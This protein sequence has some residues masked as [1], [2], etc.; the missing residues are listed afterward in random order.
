MSFV[1]IDTISPKYLKRA[2]RV[3][4]IFVPDFEYFF[5]FSNNSM[6]SIYDFIPPEV[7]SGFLMET[8]YS[9]Y[10][11]RFHEYYST[12]F[13]DYKNFSEK[14]RH[15]NYID[16]LKLY[17]LARPDV[18][19]KFFMRVY[20]AFK[21]QKKNWLVSNNGSFFF[22]YTKAQRFLRVNGNDFRLARDN[23][24]HYTFPEKEPLFL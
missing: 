5:S 19:D 20:I 9:Y 22:R 15:M 4:E 1:I 24:S 6:I 14:F 18:N 13:C 3:P 16:K 7:S 23:V 17:A 2:I 21:T 11:I 10:F 12:T 8:E